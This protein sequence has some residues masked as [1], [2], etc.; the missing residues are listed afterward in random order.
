MDDL[1][2]NFTS[3]GDKILYHPGA[4]EDLRQGRM[5]PIVLHLMPT[6][7]CNLSCCFCSV[8]DRGKAGNLHPDLP[9]STMMSV[10][11]ELIPLGLNAIIISGGGE[12]TLYREINLLIHKLAHARLDIGIITNGIDFNKHIIVESRQKLSWV[13]VSA[14]TL[15]YRD[16]LQLPILGPQTILGLS[17]IIN[18]KTTE[19]TFRRL[20][21]LVES[22]IVEG[23]QIRYIR[24]LPDC[25]LP[26][27]DL[28]L[29][30]ESLHRLVEKLGPPF[31]HQWKSHK[32]PPECHLGRV[33]PVLY[34]DGRIYPCDSIVLNSPADDKRFHSE[35]ALC[36]WH[37]VGTF[38]RKKFAGSLVDTAKCPHCVFAAQN[39][40]LKR[41]VDGEKM[42]DPKGH[43]AHVNFI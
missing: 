1:L 23:K 21:G 29:A 19:D 20:E 30:H 34:T 39:I 43:L 11:E 17:Y 28:E 5:H 13:R 41:I 24:M 31:F 32:T 9:I 25:N 40:L 3:T 12:P 8:A 33:H 26:T 2:K 15:D 35:Y 7:K 10:V 38:Y 27:D 6:E 14:N 18:P 42:P 37:E 4:I 22:G 36:H 16:N